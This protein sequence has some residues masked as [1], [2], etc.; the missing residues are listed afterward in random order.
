[1]SVRVETSGPAG[2]EELD[3]ETESRYARHLA[4][5]KK[6]REKYLKPRRS[7]PAPPPKP[8]PKPPPP[9]S[10]TNPPGYVKVSLLPT[11]ERN[12]NITAREITLIYQR[13]RPIYELLPPNRRGQELVALDEWRN[14]QLAAVTAAPAAKTLPLL[15]LKIES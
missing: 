15:N 2:F 5:F 10:Q 9:P 1:M 7:K 4:H 13:Q 12:P 6:Q 8:P 14:N 11:V 3:G